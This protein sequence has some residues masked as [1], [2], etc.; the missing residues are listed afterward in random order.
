MKLLNI[1]VLLSVYLALA[2][3]ML[4]NEAPLEAILLWGG[5]LATLLSFYVLIPSIKLLLRSVDLGRGLIA[6]GDKRH[7]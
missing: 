3:V 7:P 1:A 6:G 5:I 4:F 2:I